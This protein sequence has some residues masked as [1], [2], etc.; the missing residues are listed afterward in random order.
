M[1]DQKDFPA[2]DD[3]IQTVAKNAFSLIGLR[4]RRPE[5]G[6]ISFEVGEGTP[7]HHGVDLADPGT[8]GMQTVVMPALTVLRDSIVRQAL[9]QH[10]E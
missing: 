5:P 4:I 1:T 10:K 2:T 6:K 8:I 7:F 9:S 3:M